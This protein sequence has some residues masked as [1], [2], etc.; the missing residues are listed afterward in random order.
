M[1]YTFYTLVAICLL[2]GCGNK[3]PT[4]QETISKYYQARNAGNF[5]AIRACVND[6]ITLT[7][8]DYVMPYSHDSF[9]EVFKWDSI[10]KPSY[11]L[12]KVEEK[13]NEV[14]ASVVLTSLRYRFLKNNPMTCTFKFSFKANKISRIAAMGY[15]DA[16]WALWE[17]ERDSLVYWIDNNHP[18]LN[19]FIHDMTMDGALNYLEAITLYEAAKNN[20]TQ[21]KKT[22]NR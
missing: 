9:Y 17:R 6:S 11:E 14:I 22:N 7:E 19:G 10:F 2:L 16:D 13:N 20:Q 5:N 1:K 8:G 21:S 4:P 18:N 12:L 3:Q 15:M